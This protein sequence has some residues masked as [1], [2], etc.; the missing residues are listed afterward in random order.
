MLYKALVAITAVTFAVTAF[1]ASSADARTKRQYQQYQS[2]GQSAGQAGWGP[3][4]DGRVTGYV[5]T[6]GYQYQQY[7]IHGVPMGPYCH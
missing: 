2:Y 5:R 3:S 6:C 7:D 1:N 4:L